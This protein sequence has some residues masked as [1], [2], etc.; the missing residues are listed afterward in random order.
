MPKIKIILHKIAGGKIGDHPSKSSVP[1]LFKVKNIPQ[2]LCY[3]QKYL[4]P[5]S[6]KISRSY[7]KTVLYYLF[8]IDFVKNTQI[9][10]A[11]YLE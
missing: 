1:P 11:K 9:F 2:S 7:R 10:C 6:P 4:L 5:P 8:N 3:K